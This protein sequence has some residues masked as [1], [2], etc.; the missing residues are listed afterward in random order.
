MTDNVQFAEAIG[1]EARD[2]VE[3]SSC[4]VE[5]ACEVLEL[6]GGSILHDKAEHGVVTVISEEIATL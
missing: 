3:Q 5:L 1:V 2:P 6:P 4:G